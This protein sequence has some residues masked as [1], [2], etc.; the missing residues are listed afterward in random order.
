MF[1]PRFDRASVAGTFPS[2]AITVSQK[3]PTSP[4][5]GSSCQKPTPR[6]GRHANGDSF[7]SQGHFL[8]EILNFQE[9]R[10]ET[11]KIREAFYLLHEILLRKFG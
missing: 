2:R 5:S 3:P 1:R 9:V 4:S 10:W 7:P 11:S 8:T 6:S